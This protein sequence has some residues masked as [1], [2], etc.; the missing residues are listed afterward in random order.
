MV[1]CV[2]HVCSMI[3]AIAELQIVFYFLLFDKKQT[4]K[5]ARRPVATLRKLIVQE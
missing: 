3:I 1:A 2:I 4:V 5:A